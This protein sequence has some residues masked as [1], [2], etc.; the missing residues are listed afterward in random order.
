VLAI[1]CGLVSSHYRVIEGQAYEVRRKMFN[2]TEQLAAGSDRLTAG[3]PGVRGHGRPPPL[4]CLPAR[5]ER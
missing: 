2:F 1:I 3:G 4:R 5:A